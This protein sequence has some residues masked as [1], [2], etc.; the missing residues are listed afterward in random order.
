M[1]RGVARPRRRRRRPRRERE[2]G[3]LFFCAFFLC[4]VQQKGAKEMLPIEME[5]AKREKERE[6]KRGERGPDKVGLK[7]LAGRLSRRGGSTPP[8]GD[9]GACLRGLS[10]NG[11]VGTVV[12]EGGSHWCGRGGGGQGGRANVVPLSRAAPAARRVIAS[13]RQASRVRPLLHTTLSGPTSPSWRSVGPSVGPSVP[14][15]ILAFPLL[16][17]AVSS[18]PVARAVR[19]RSRMNRRLL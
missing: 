9:F 13:P 2:I 14:L 6:R 4:N 7:A 11:E 19:I 15:P 3:E 5:Q 1:D 18:G 10:G 16:D 8:E 17:A 12:R